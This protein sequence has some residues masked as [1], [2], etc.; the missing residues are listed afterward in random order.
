MEPIAAAFRLGNQTLASTF[1]ESI[2]VVFQRANRLY[3]I[4]EERIMGM[5]RGIL[6][7]MLGVPLPIVILL[8]L[9]WHH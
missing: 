7:W 1:L 6:L 8:A 2:C 3:L 5:G 9:F 4:R